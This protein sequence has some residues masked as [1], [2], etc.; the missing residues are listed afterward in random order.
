MINVKAHCAAHEYLTSSMARQDAMQSIYLK[1]R[2]V[3]DVRQKRSKV[4]TVKA[5]GAAHE[6]QTS[7]M[8][9]QDSKHTISRKPHIGL[10]CKN[11]AKERR[12]KGKLSVRMITRLLQRIVER[13]SFTSFF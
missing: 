3:A 6:N 5:H 12:L 13:P 10:I 4:T 1:N 11:R 8:A 7:S 2:V 9:R